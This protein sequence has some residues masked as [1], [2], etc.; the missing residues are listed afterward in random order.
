MLSSRLLAV[1]RAVVA[2][3]SLTRAAASLGYTVSAVSQQLAQL[4][5]QAGV[6][7]FEKAGRGVRPTAA[8]LLLAEHA[9]RILAQ[10]ADAEQALDDLRAGRTGRIRVVSFHSAGESLLP[11]AIAT[12]HEQIPGVHVRPIV[13]E[14]PGALRRLRDGE[15]DLVVMV[16]PYARGAEPADDLR[17]WHLLDDEYRVL[18]RH[19]HPLARRRVVPVEALAE[20]DWVVTTGPSDYVRDTT[21]AMCRR[22]GFIPRVIAEGDEFNV[23]QGYVAAGLGAALVPLLALGAVRGEV[24]VRRLTPPPRPRHIWLATRAT[25]ADQ[26]VVARMIDAL[27]AAAALATGHQHARP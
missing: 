21:V 27:Q 3:G 17:R 5:S 18:L 8:G 23:T 24:A 11:R 4:E 9:V 20:V 7:L 26:P 25:L 6:E 19:D 14:T 15:A 12:L 16:E 13:D 10:I 2:D 1:H 22:A